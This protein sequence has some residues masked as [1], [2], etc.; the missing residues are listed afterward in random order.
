MVD[1]KT[2]AVVLVLAAA[3]LTSVSASLL[4]SLFTVQN[5]G[6]VAGV[7]VSVSPASLNWGTISP[8]ASKTLQVQVSNTGNVPETLSMSTQGLPSYLAVTWDKAGTV[9]QPG[10]STTASF[11]LTV[12]GSASQGSFSFNITITG[13]GGD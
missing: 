5:S 10:Q 11:T 8:G 12:A 2:L 9:L 4:T 1:K 3:L 7:G 6:Q 13:T